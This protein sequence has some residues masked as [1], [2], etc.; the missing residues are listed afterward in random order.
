MITNGTEIMFSII[1]SNESG[2]SHYIATLIAQLY[3]QAHRFNWSCCA[4][5]DTTM[6]LYDSRFRK[7]L[8][9]DRI[10]I[11]K[12]QAASVMEHH[13]LIYILNFDSGLPPVTLAFYDAAWENFNSQESMAQT[14]RYL[15]ESSGVI[16]L[17]DPLQLPYV[18]EKFVASGQGGETE[19]PDLVQAN[20]RASNMFQRLINVLRSKERI[21][22][23][24]P[25][26]PVA[27][28]L[29]KIDALRF[30][31]T[32]ESPLFLPSFHR[33][34]GCFCRSDAARIDEYLR[35]FLMAVDRNRELL[36]LVKQ[37]DNCCCFGMSALG[38]NPKSSG[39][40]LR[41]PPRPM[42]VLD[43]F[44]WLLAQHDRIATV[45]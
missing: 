39:Q 31:L 36:S 26:I 17:I 3:S 8:Y 23:Q 44:L 9:E 22:R 4:S 15:N 18:R 45:E 2:K 37:L 7:R 34:Y 19:L 20:A 35:S 1:G 21:S 6:E 24:K 16:F 5:D 10:V 13:P 25:Q 30:M 14:T 42:R 32:D 33:R 28:T 12:T 38:Q 43:P 27:L 29:S 11:S 40:R 41:F